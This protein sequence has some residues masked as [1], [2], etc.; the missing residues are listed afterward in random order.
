MNPSHQKRLQLEV[1]LSRAKD[2]FTAALRRLEESSNRLRTRRERRRTLDDDLVTFR[3]GE[4]YEHE[5]TNKLLVYRSAEDMEK[6][7]I[8]ETS[9]REV[10]VDLARERWVD[11][12]RQLELAQTHERHSSTGPESR[13]EAVPI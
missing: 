3:A 7:S 6:L 5:L 4:F 10:E 2:A 1:D 12:R 8:R 9:D 13:S 11:C